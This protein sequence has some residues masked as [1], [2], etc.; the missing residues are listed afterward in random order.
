MAVM[1]LLQTV[2]ARAQAIDPP[3]LSRKTA[4][5][6]A[7]LSTATPGQNGTT[8]AARVE[9]FLRQSGYD[10]QNVRANSWFINRKGKELPQIR[11]LVGAGPSSIAVGAV[12]VPKRSLRVTADAMYKMMK[13]SYDLN[14]VRVCI[15]PDEDLIVIAQVKEGW[16]DL[17][18]FKAVVERVTA[19]ADRAYGEMRPFLNTP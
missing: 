14:Y 5:K 4:T 2:A 12:V 15:D 19:A 11:V 10:Y 3:H 6:A 7:H 17:Q 1:A 8:F 16:L 13:L 9:S 18:E